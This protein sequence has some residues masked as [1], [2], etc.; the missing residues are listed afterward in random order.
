MALSQEKAAHVQ[1][2]AQL[3]LD[4]NKYPEKQVAEEFNK[5]VNVELN[6]S[7]SVHRRCMLRFASE[8]KIT[9]AKNSIRK[10]RNYN[11]YTCIKLTFDTLF[12]YYIVEYFPIYAI[13]K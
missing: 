13:N 2:C 3:W 11:T 4:T 10:V 7:L 5:S 8:S 12:L 1:K 6:Q 9:R